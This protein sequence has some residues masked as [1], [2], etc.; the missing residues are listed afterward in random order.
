MR[1]WNSVFL[2]AALLCNGRL[3]AA[4]WPQFLGPARNGVSPETF[5]E[6]VWPKP[7][8][9]I[10]WRASIGSGF[11]GPVV[12]AGKVVAFHRRGDKEIVEAFDARTGK[13]LWSSDYPTI[14]RDDF[15]MDEGPRGTP[16]IAGG[17]VYTFGVE[18]ALSCRELETGAK[19]WSVDT[20][21][22]FQARKGFFGLA[23]SPLVDGKKVLV[24]LGGTG[25]AGIVA[26]DTETGK[27][28]WK[29]T[30]HEAG[31][32]SPV[33]AAIDGVSYGF[34]FTREGL[35]ALNPEDGK[36]Y[37]QFPWRSRTSASVNAATPLVIGNLVFLSAS[38]Q[39]GA[40][41]LRVK[42][43]GCEKVW[44]GDDIL[45]NHYATSIYHDGCLYGY[46]G[47][48]ES[49]PRLRCV[50]L[51]S[52]QVRWTVEHF[53]GGNL[54]LAGNELLLLTDKGELVGASAWPV[55]YVE[56][57]RVQI[58]SGEVRAYPAL[59]EGRYYARDRQQLVCVGL[60]GAGTASSAGSR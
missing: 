40:A 27:V 22:A 15:G 14:Y 26:F 16:A 25:Q 43:R 45:S 29:A 2:S 46:D 24:S 7:A 13:H 51:K 50:E 58:L 28:L 35:V 44:A 5:A 47:R 19:V 57:G 60:A 17:R 53:G 59:A 49:G 23:C 10:L 38:Y 34:F 41:L 4:D 55:K 3:G 21:A 54:I 20:R 30:E 39:T 31:Y 52:G 42:D 8:P 32:S 18:G 11:S 33:V 48:Q 9:A 36:I 56:H 12:S 1:E 6:P 37:F